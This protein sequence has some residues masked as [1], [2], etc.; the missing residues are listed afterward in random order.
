MNSEIFWKY[1]GIILMVV[2][3]SYQILMPILK[4]FGIITVS[5]WVCFIPL[6][7]VILFFAWFGFSFISGGGIRYNM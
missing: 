6:F 3:I 1:V 5:W 4:W 2:W 7:I